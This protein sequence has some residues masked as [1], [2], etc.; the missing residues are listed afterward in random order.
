MKQTKMMRMSLRVLSVLLGVLALLD[1]IQAQDQS[2][3]VIKL[4]IVE[5][6]SHIVVTT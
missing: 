2:G 5:F 3:L 1:L 4:Y 6:M